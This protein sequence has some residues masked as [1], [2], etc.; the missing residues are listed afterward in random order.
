MNTEERMDR[1]DEALDRL[2]ERHEAIT[3]S[4]ELLLQAQQADG[5]HIRALM[6]IAESRKRRIADLE[7]GEPA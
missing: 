6:P 7:G 5:E 2:R 4:A 3:H 1:F